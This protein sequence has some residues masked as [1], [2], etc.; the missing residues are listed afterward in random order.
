MKSISK[1]ITSALMVAALGVSMTA[2]DDWTE[3]ESIDTDFGTIETADPAAY[4]KYLENLRAY[5]DKNHKQVFVWFNNSENAFGSQ[6]HRVSALPDSVDVVVLQ[7]VKAV[8]NQM[9]EEMYKMRV[10]KGMKFIYCINFS[11]IKADWT[12]KCEELA[13]KRLEFQAAN[14][15]DAEIPEE[16]QDPDFI[17]YIT[18]AWTDQLSYFN[19]VGFDGLMAAYDGKTTNYMTP[20]EIAEYEAQTNAFLGCFSDWHARNPQYPIDFMGKPQNISDKAILNDFRYVFLSAALTATDKDMFT[21]VYLNTN[22]VIGDSKVGLV[23]SLPAIDQAADS[24]TGIFATGAWAADGLAD[25]TAA[26]EVGAVGFYNVQNDY[27]LSNGT[28]DD[29][30]QYI[31]IVNPAAK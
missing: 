15:E 2:C 1:Y 24:K 10:D 20:A 25:W 28:Y 5:R 21:Q 17:K 26:H 8:T 16:L 27:F 11:D 7:N 9:V 18:D 14:G 31:Q 6:G 12:A 22:G 13:A 29:V 19:A 4:V 30:R 3:P 23:A